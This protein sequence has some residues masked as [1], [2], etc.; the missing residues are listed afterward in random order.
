MGR[1]EHKVTITRLANGYLLEP[2]Y[3][4]EGEIHTS[5]QSLFRNV[6]RM[7]RGEDYEFDEGEDGQFIVHGAKD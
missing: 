6:N 4:Y 2:E 1:R 7:F 5:L 3:C